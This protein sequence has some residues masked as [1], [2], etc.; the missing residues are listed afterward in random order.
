MLGGL[1]S[2]GAPD[3]YAR[4]KIGEGRLCGGGTS[5]PDD[6]VVRPRAAGH[7]RAGLDDVPDCGSPVSG[8]ASAALVLQAGAGEAPGLTETVEA[9]GTIHHYVEPR[10]SIK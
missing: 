6:F 1:L 8:V 7:N 10:Q 9:G 2:I 5:G 4:M 3:A